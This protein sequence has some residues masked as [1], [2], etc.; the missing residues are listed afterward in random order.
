MAYNR[1]RL[2]FRN[3]IF[4]KRDN[5]NECFEVRTGHQ[6]HTIQHLFETTKTISTNEDDVSVKCVG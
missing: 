2:W 1:N 6:H 3:K 5:D 4:L